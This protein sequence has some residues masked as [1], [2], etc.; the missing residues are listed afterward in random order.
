MD[1][2][3]MVSDA[4]KELFD[5]VDKRGF[6]SEE[7]DRVHRAYDLAEE[8]HRP[9]R[10]KSGEPYILHP[11]AVAMIVAN[12]IGLGANPICAALLHDVV[13]D[14]DHTVKEIREMFGED[15]A[16]LVNVVTKR[17]ADKYETSL[18]VDNYKQMLQSIHYDIRALLLKL[19][20]RLH[21]M[22]TLDSMLPHKRLK[23]ASETD[24]FYAPLANRLGLYRIKT[25]LENLSFRYRLPNEYD[26]V[27]GQIARY[28]KA[29]A[30]AAEAWMAPLR[31][32]LERRGIEATVVCE[33]RSAYSI[34]AKMQEDSIAF[35]E[36]EHIRI[37]HIVYKNW[38]QKQ[39]SEKEMAL[40]VYSI[41]SN[42]YTEK[43]GSMNSYLDVSK[44][45]NYRSLHCK[46]MGN[47]GRWMEVHIASSEM[48][49]IAN[50]GCLVER[51]HGVDRWIEN[52]RVVLKEIAEQGKNG[53]FM[54][55]VRSTF[56]EDDI[57][58]FT[59]KGKMVV[60]P[61]G[62]T[63][64]DFAFEIHNKVGEQMKFAVINDKLCSAK[65]VLRKG[66]R[67]RIGT[68][69]VPSI[70]KSW[71]DSVVTY[72]ARNGIRRFL[73]HQAN[74][75]NEEFLRCPVCKP[76]FGDEIIGFKLS[77]GRT[78]VHQCHCR[79]AIEKAAQSGDCIVEDVSMAQFEQMA[80]PIHFHVKSVNKD[81]LLLTIV[82]LISDRMA[83]SLG[84]LHSTIV[85]DI[86]STDFE[87]YVHSHS[88]IQELKDAIAALPNVYGLRSY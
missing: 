21:N 18:Q 3:K 73:N 53:G 41:V 75:V 54:E 70:D 74:K 23:I 11:I 6:T 26:E 2:E 28:V 49:R 17:K 69:E 33:P 10:R 51:E 63:A 22:R 43:P 56:Y 80:F 19:A 38:K 44:D 66:D 31:D 37:V 16:M 65:T 62:A 76:I 86:V 68:D 52:F 39:M 24:Y 87:V 36:V 42:I 5:C 50:I 85:D 8:A 29:H 4:K 46:L 35:S 15:V 67:V 81:Q 47:E 82:S 20:D 60:L 30:D 58:V 34:W 79:K 83:L 25:E 48:R 13:E 72:K 59:P 27:K 77:D 1:Y 45:N 84:N 61:K 78:E 12:E 88:E 14:T 57:Y 7:I 71:L 32:A 9:Q 40:L 55:D 64:I